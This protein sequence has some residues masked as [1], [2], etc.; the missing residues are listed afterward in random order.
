MLFIQGACGDINPLGGVQADYTNCDRLGTI[1][2]GEIVRVYGGTETR[3]RD[4]HLT[5]TASEIEVALAPLPDPPSDGNPGGYVKGL[6][7][8][9]HMGSN[10][11]L[12]EIQ[13]L[14]IGD[15]GIVSAAAE[16]F[17]ETGLAA[18]TRS[19]FARTF[20]A[21]YTNGCVG[22]VPTAQAYPLGGYEVRVA[23]IGYG[24]PMPVAPTAEQEV[25][26]ACSVALEEVHRS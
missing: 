18:K 17:V 20:F 15:L 19:P 13:A 23:H 26:R 9:A 6:V 2:A 4:L 21:G 7:R 11:P 10:G 8:S 22:Y 24:L 5:A 14:G 25:V 3:E 12:I 16:P 1:L